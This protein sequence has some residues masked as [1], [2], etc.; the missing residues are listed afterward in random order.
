ML[1]RVKL[2]SDGTLLATIE[3][4][5]SGDNANNLTNIITRIAGESKRVLLDISKLEHIN[6]FGFRALLKIR[7]V[8]IEKGGTV[9]LTRPRGIVLKILNIFKYETIF[10]IVPTVH[11]AQIKT[12]IAA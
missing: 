6:A 1:T 2:Q 3:G 9:L 8:I 5:L 10:E 4:Q 7:K 12:E 11:A